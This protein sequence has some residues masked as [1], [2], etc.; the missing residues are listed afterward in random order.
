[1][2]TKGRGMDRE[3]QRDREHAGGGVNAKSPHVLLAFAVYTAVAVLAAALVIVYFVRHNVEANSKQKVADHAAFVAHAVVPEILPQ[4]KLATPLRGKQLAVVDQQVRREL[5]KNGALRVK[6]YNAEGATVYSNDKSLIGSRFDDAGEFEEVMGGETVA[7]VASLNH[8]G[9]DGKNVKAIESYAPIYYPG[10]NKPA[11]VFEVYNDYAQAAGSI[12]QQAAPLT[13]AL[14]LVLLGLYLALWPILRRTTRALEFS[15]DELRRRA[16]D[17]NENLVH[18]AEI[19]ERLRSTILDL[20][21]SETALVHSQEETIM[22]LSLAVESRDAETGSH[23][24]RMGR[25]CTLI[26]G[27][28]GWEEDRCELLRIASPLHD[29]GKIAIPDAVLQKP[30]ALTPEERVMMEKHAEIGHKILAGS[31]SPLL[32]LAARIALTHHE[33]WDGTG[34]PNGLQ[35]ENIPVEGRIAAIADVFDAL[36]SDRV[37]RKA[38]SIE[39]A[40]SIMTEGRGSHFDPELLDVFLGSIQEVLAI[41]DGKVHNID[42]A[43]AKTD[44][45]RRRRRSAGA[46]AGMPQNAA[47]SGDARQSLVG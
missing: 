18:R 1:M 5:L 27:K 40:L 26:A 29:V 13:I 44:R 19:E 35:G 30:G 4:D 6:V 33:Q 17:L 36:T 24:E 11:G 43:R 9:G 47:D 22:R 16:D 2:Q 45:S 34:Y 23:I 41:R 15:N 31:D 39:K 14:L 32:D 8:E 28:I 10:S 21:R 46:A 3:R 12:R 38:M 42:P 20:E 25:Y 37:Y 7:S